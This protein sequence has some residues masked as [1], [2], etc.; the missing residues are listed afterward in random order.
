MS[1]PLL[2]TYYDAI[3]H[4]RT[5]FGALAS[6]D[7]E[8]RVRDAIQ[9]AYL[10]IYQTKRWNFLAKVG[11]IAIVAPY[12]I[13]TIEFNAANRIV[14]LTSGTFPTW[15]AY[16]QIQFGTDENVYQ[17]AS[18]T[19]GKHVILEAEFCPLANIAA[20]TTYHIDRC[21]YPLPPNV[22]GIEGIYDETKVWNSYYVRPDEFLHRQRDFRGTGRPW[23]WTIM[24]SPDS[25][26]SMA[27]FLSS[28]PTAAETFDYIYYRACRDLT[29]DGHA[30]YSSQSTFTLASAAAGTTGATFATVSLPTTVVG[31]VLRIADASATAPPAG[32]RSVNPFMEQRI[33]ASRT[34]AT[35]VVVDAAWDVGKVSTHFTI[36][37]PIDLPHY[38]MGAFYRRCELEFAIISGD[39]KR[40]GQAQTL[41]D[42]A[43]RDAMGRDNVQ[44]IPEDL[45]GWRSSLPPEY[46]LFDYSG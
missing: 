26:G 15:A 28:R 24:G 21:V 3:H 13:G 42:M 6:E 22:R 12:S 23:F 40:V 45:C 32:T 10:E 7:E 11:R 17:V 33:I 37:D 5:A 16:G 27:L 43:L 39:D 46:I 4:L 18:R 38:M 36:S 41:Y 25:Y 1:A 29:C 9:A 31:A 19:D 14:T 34:D 30:R 8:D 20:L 35:T 2:T 44:P